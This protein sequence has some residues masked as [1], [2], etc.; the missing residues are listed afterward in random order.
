MALLADKNGAPGAVL[1]QKN[2][3]VK[4]VAGECCAVAIDHVTNGP[5]LIAGKTYWVAAI[6]PN[7]N[8]AKTWDAWNLDSGLTVGNGAVTRDGKKWIVS[9]GTSNAFAV[10]G[11]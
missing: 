2:V 8:E 9:Q 7:A 1:T 5:Q 10:F 4:Q 3:N 11:Q 6:L